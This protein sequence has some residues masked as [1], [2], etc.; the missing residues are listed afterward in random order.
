MLHFARQSS[1][2]WPSPRCS[3]GSGDCRSRTRPNHL[4]GSADL[5][6]VVRAEGKAARALRRLALDRAVA[7][8]RKS[9]TD[10]LVE[11]EAARQ[12]AG[13]QPAADAAEDARQRPTPINA[14][15]DPLRKPTRPRDDE[16]ANRPGPDQAARPP[17]QHQTRRGRSCGAGIISAL[18]FL[19]GLRWIDDN[20]R[21]IFGV[22][23]IGFDQSSKMQKKPSCKFQNTLPLTPAR[24]RLDRAGAQ[25][26]LR[27]RVGDLEL[28]APGDGPPKVQGRGSPGSTAE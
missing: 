24:R 16:L 5:N 7:P 26:G 13:A 4:A 14:P 10:R 23:T 22:N 6:S 17:A 12:V 19:S 11:M 3:G 27:K 2:C 1:E 15:A 25:A 21:P 18:T 20:S 28:I 8:S 9:F